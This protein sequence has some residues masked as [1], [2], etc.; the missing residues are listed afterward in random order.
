MNFVKGEPLIDFIRRHNA[1]SVSHALVILNNFG[2]DF[3]YEYVTNYHLHSKT[4]T[5]LEKEFEKLLER[6]DLLLGVSTFR[7]LLISDL[8]KVNI[9]DEVEKEIKL[10]INKNRKYLT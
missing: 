4:K 2:E 5:L 8:L 7:N 1:I 10:S 6:E 3:V 9:F